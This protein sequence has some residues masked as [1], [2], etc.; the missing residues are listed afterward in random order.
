MAATT[1][2]TD[3]DWVRIREHAE[4]IFGCGPYSI[5][6]PTHW[7]RVERFG[8]EVARDSGA[9]ET[10]VRLFA[11]F[12]DS[13]RLTDGADY[14]HGPRAADLLG[15]FVPDLVTLEPERVATLEHAIRHHTDGRTSSDPTI[16]TCWDADRLD[17]GRAGI[18]PRAAFMSTE[19]G[20]KRVALL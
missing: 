13:C 3:E 2:M 12:H 6:G 20:R 5:H 18:R 17:L 11:I 19:A 1:T 15:S 16:G 7:Q 4:S 10:L 14:Q 9:D 8:L